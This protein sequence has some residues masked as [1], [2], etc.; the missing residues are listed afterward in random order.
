MCLDDNMCVRVK[1]KKRI[2]TS[3]YMDNYSHDPRCLFPNLSRVDFTCLLHITRRGALS[4][5]INTH[6]P[7]SFRK[8]RWILS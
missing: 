3:R 5:Y 7:A 8:V 4:L 6:A 2:R 1:D